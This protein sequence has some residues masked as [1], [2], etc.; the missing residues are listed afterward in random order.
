MASTVQFNPR[1]REIQKE[2]EKKF[3]YENNKELNNKKNQEL[4]NKKKNIE[5]KNKK[6]YRIKE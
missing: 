5:L 3:I 2:T 4:K 6:K 1:N